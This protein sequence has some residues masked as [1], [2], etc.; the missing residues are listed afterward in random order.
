MYRYVPSCHVLVV[1]ARFHETRQFCCM[2][3]ELEWPV[4]VGIDFEHLYI[5]YLYI[6]FFLIVHSRYVI[7]DIICSILYFLVSTGV[8]MVH[9]VIIHVR[10]C[11]LHRSL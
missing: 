4:N 1:V 2:Q 11:V 8:F 6:R 9:N 7:A 3:L 5:L 10:A